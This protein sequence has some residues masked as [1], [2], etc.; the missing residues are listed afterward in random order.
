MTSL[1]SSWHWWAA[2]L[3]QRLL[4]VWSG[5]A[6]SSRWLTT[7]LTNGQHASV[8]VNTL[9]CLCSCQW[10][11]FWT[12]LVTVNLFSLYLNFVFHMTLDAEVRY[13]SM[14]CDVSRSQG[15][16][17]TLFRWGELFRVSV[18]VF[19]LLTAVQKLWVMITSVLPRFFLNH[20]VHVE[21]AMCINTSNAGW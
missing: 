1:S 15:N 12:Y 8:L 11:T 16:V 18:K 14:K 10:W 21:G 2:S 13:K 17:S 4:H 19:F 9:A 3:R 5:E 20:R 7:Q 6:W